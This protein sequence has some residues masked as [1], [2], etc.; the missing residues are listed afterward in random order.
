[1]KKTYSISLLFIFLLTASAFSFQL[2][3]TSLKVNVR[4][5]LGNLVN[6]AEVTLYESKEDYEKSENPLAQKSTDVKGNAVFED[7]EA[8]VYYI[9]AEK[10]DANNFGAGE[11]TDTLTAKRMNKVT[12]IISE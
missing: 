5:E 10:G 4:N 7:L 9:N 1:M 3:K 6:G 11:K 8:K 12:I 2:F